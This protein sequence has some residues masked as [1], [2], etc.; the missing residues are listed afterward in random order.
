VEARAGDGVL[1]IYINF[2]VKRRDINGYIAMLL[3]LPSL[4]TLKQLLAAFI[5]RNTGV[6]LALAHAAE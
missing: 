2:T 1:F 6:H 5:S 3:D 4:V